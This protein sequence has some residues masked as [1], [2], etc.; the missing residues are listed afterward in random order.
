MKDGVI[1]VVG[2]VIARKYERFKKATEELSCPH[3]SIIYCTSS[4][5]NHSQSNLAS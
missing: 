5:F 3:R 4:Y 2:G 1:V